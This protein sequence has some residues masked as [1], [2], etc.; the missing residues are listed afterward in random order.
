VDQRTID[1]EDL[2][3]WSLRVPEVNKE[4][5]KHKQ[6]ATIAIQFNEKCDRMRNFAICRRLRQP[7]VNDEKKYKKSCVGNSECYYT[8][9]VLQKNMDTAFY[10]FRTRNASRF[11]WAI[12]ISRGPDRSEI[13]FFGRA[14]LRR[15]FLHTP[16]IILSAPPRFGLMLP[17]M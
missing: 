1:F 11:L 8:S 7:T 13:L 4:I 5:S 2:T 3:T 15:A 16:K 10:R 17:S 12:S 9:Y 6:I 14:C